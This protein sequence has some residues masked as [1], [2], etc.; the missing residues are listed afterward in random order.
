MERLSGYLRKDDSNFKDMAAAC[1]A[2][3]EGNPKQFVGL[4]EEFLRLRAIRSARDSKESGLQ[5]IVE[6]C[7]FM[8]GRCVPEMCLLANPSK[9]WGDSRFGFVDI[10]IA[11]S[12]H[13][14]LVR[15]PVIELKNVSLRGV[16]VG[17][18]EGP[19]DEPHYKDLLTLHSVLKTE[20]EEQLLKR[21]YVYWQKES[22]TWQ[23]Q[24]I[25]D[26]KY[27]AF[28]QVKRY[29]RLIKNGRAVGSAS[30]VLDDRIRCKNGKT[31][32]D[33]Y[34][35]LCIGNARVLGWCVGTEEAPYVFEK[36]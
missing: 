17:T 32:L 11:S 36:Y 29:L 15:M 4:L 33:G 18:T 16:W 7:W 9:M 22:G 14:P 35:L 34:V 2:F 21:R 10:F 24:T 27:Q 20:P 8:D 3:I 19:D 13:A 25:E 31:R 1:G 30:G 28:D 6:L 12:A 23:S 26:L 5:S